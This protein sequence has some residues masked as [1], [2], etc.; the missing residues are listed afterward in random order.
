MDEFDYD[1]PE[2]LIAQVPLA[3]R[4]ASRLL[5]LDRQSGHVTHRMFPDILSYLNAG[6]AL[7]IN[8][9]KVIPARLIGRKKVG[10]AL[11]EVLLLHR[12]SA[13]EWEA[14]VR[15][16]KR[17][18]VG[19]EIE[20]GDGELTC[21]ITKKLPEGGR[22]VKFSHSGVFEEVLDRLGEMPLPP[23][24]KEKLADRQRYQTVYA[25]EE[26]SA[27]APTAGLH[28][29][30]GILEQIRALGIHVVTITLHVGLGTFR[31]VKVENIQEHQMH[32]EYYRMNPE[33][34]QTLNRVKE[35]G[36]RIVAVGTTSCRVLETVTREDGLVH[37]G[38][39]WTDIFIYPGHR[40]RAV[41]A[42]LTNFHLPKSTLMM[43]IS[44]FAGR[45]HVLG[46]YHEAVK[47]EYRFFSF[48]DAML[49]L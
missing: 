23:Y 36:G 29:T 41:D 37:P 18:R 35:K 43:L 19:T 49:I 9:T 28:F 48:G 16:G 22:L 46:A 2:A 3:D 11:A 4:A 31:P 15:P 14:L 25:R 12:H 39:G 33:A 30:Q 1:L 17:L 32:S 13:T 21:I 47:Q 44:A 34:A 20:F 5:V 45:D 7:V 26:G 8:D 42:L 27:A 24:I 6:D 10:G 38:S 40:F